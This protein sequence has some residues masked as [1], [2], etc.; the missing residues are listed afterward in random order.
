M[1]NSMVIT[2]TI[3]PR[4][5]IGDPPGQSRGTFFRDLAGRAKRSS[6][7]VLSHLTGAPIRLGI[8]HPLGKSTSKL[9]VKIRL[10]LA[11]AFVGQGILHGWIECLE[12]ERSLALRQ[13]RKIL[14][15]QEFTR[16]E[17]NRFT[18]GAKTTSVDLAWLVDFET[19]DSA[20]EW[21]ER[22]SYQI[23]VLLKHKDDDRYGIQ[24]FKV[25]DNSNEISLQIVLSQGN[26]I[27]LSIQPETLSDFNELHMAKDVNSDD[28]L[29]MTKS[30]IMVEVTVGSQL[31]K[32]IDEGNPRGWSSV[33]LEACVDSIW[34]EAGF[35]AKYI[36]DPARLCTTSYPPAARIIH[37]RYLAHQGLDA[38]NKLI[39][40]D[41]LVR[42]G[43]DLHLRPS[44]NSPLDD[45]DNE[46]VHDPDLQ[47]LGEEHATNFADLILK[48][49]V[50][51]RV[52]PAEHKFL[53]GA[54]GEKLHYS[55]RWH[56]PD[57]MQSRIVSTHTEAGLKLALSARHQPP[58]EAILPESEPFSD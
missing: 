12:S 40:D 25:V 2:G 9:E 23:K 35:T 33:S 53:D 55:N 52:R 47:D 14:L 5:K 31:L 20:K 7:R 37:Q 26:G 16:E 38:E 4:R 32:G 27:K 48:D 19:L 54:I 34:N 11:T 42:S 18:S 15:E 8:R 46:H 1:I 39:L 58:R 51:I 3:S 41:Q 57:E 17:V 50:D 56:L 44:G 28:I 45:P 36:P 24:D 30:K 43:F 13:I 6:N 29:A 22:A 21:L 10:P 49:G